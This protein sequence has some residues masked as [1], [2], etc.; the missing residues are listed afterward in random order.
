MVE[1]VL[2]HVAKLIQN[3][4]IDAKEKV[5]EENTVFQTLEETKKRLEAIIEHSFDG[6]YITDGEGKTII[7][8]KAYEQITGLQKKEV[9]GRNMK[10]LV[11]SGTISASGSLRAIRENRVVTL[12]QEFKTGKKAMITSTPIYNEEGM[13]VMVVTNVRDLTEIYH[14]KEKVEEQEQEEEKLRRNLEHM[15]SAIHCKDMIAQDENTLHAVFMADKVAPLDATVILLGETGVGKEV[16]AKHIFQNSQRKEENFIKVNCGAIPE[17]LI[18]SELFGYEKG[19]FTGANRNGKI[20]LFELAD[21]GT[22]F[23]DEIGEL[24]LNMQVKL[25]RAIQEQEIE[26]IGGTKPVK[27]DV[28]IIAATNR[29]LEKMMREGTF[30]EDLYYRLMVFPIHIPP[31]RERKGDI[32][33]L[34]ETFLERLNQ[35][36]GFQKKFSESTM[37]ILKEY[38]WP[39]NIRELK[40]I[41]ERA[42]IISNGDEIEPDAIPITGSRIERKVCPGSKGLKPTNNLSKTLQ[43]IEAQYMQE[44]Y[45]K[46]GNVRDA[47]KSLGMNASTFVRKRQKYKEQI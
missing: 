26:R 14:L 33:P 13:I 21:K 28:R 39:G 44:A 42:I 46:Y 9:L 25:L 10:N 27:I 15:Q 31:L 6:I 4:K 43:E 17:N 3:I 22:I 35:K 8:N 20:G 47:A 36:Y 34:A 1:P 24:P 45:E 16:F 29:N 12:A 5:M 37:Y 11:K 19:A 2:Q 38:A 23:L 41:V 18:E 7:V 40:N 30:R 32:Q